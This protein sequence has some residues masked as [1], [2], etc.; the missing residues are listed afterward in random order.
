[1]KIKA[2]EI[3]RHSYD[4]NTG[5]AIRLLVETIEKQQ[6]EIET[7]QNQVNEILKKDK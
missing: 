3:L 5:I 4:G 1:M 6:A 2:R 7:L